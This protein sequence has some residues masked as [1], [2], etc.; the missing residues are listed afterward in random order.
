MVLLSLCSTPPTRHAHTHTHTQHTRTRFSV[1]RN[2]LLQETPDRRILCVKMAFA[3]AMAWWTACCVRLCSTIKPALLLP[4]MGTA[5]CVRLRSTIK[6]AL[7]PSM[8]TAC[9]VRL[10]STIKPK[11][12]L[13]SMG[14]VPALSEHG[15]Q[16]PLVSRASR[17]AEQ[18]GWAIARARA[19]AMKSTRRPVI[20]ASAPHIGLG[21]LRPP[22]ALAVNNAGPAAPPATSFC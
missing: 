9:C 8:G 12:L 16:A 13:P 7:L 3:L 20:C 17:S 11:L 21:F 22:H 1:A 4:S 5:C 19:A 18:T 2:D 6:P 14:E 15:S 10:C